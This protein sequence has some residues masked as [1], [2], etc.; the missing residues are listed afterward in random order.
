[1]DMEE[2]NKPKATNNVQKK[3]HIRSDEPIA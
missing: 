3:I 2:K 1:M